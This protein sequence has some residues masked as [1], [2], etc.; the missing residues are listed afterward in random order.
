MHASQLY[1]LRRSWHDDAPIF[2]SL[3]SCY[4]GSNDFI[5]DIDDHLKVIYINLSTGCL[6]L[7]SRHPFSISG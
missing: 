2:G 3:I 5:S 7:V 1:M 4:E 6:L